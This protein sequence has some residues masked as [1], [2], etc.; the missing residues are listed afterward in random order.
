MVHVPPPVDAR[1]RDDAAADAR[2]RAN[3][4]GQPAGAAVPVGTQRCELEG[5]CLAARRRRRPTAGR[6]SFARTPASSCDPPPDRAVL[7][8]RTADFW[9]RASYIYSSYKVKQVQ[10]AACRLAGWSEDR[11]RDDLW[12]PHHEWAGRQMYDL[13]VGVR[14]FYLKVWGEGGEE[15]RATRERG[16]RRGESDGRGRARSSRA[17]APPPSSHPFA[18]YVS[19]VGQFFAARSEFVPPGICAELQKLHDR[20]PPMPAAKA[21]AVIEDGL[22][23]APL[24][25]VFQWIDLESPLGSA[26]VAQVHKA[27]LR[28]AASRRTV[29]GG[30]ARCRLSP[31]RRWM[32]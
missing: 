15:E 10:D 29:V 19:Q 1:T 4:A 22:G 8:L 5:G 32:R 7:A 18:L 11:L 24:G 9:R 16:W 23:G 26:S 31:V 21:R 27:R 30:L 13:A 17:S 6:H 3:Y 12:A 14:G 20:V 28:G 25:D 2:A